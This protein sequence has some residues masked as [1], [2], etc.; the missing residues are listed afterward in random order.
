MELGILVVVA[1]AVAIAACYWPR[2]PAGASDRE[3]APSPADV[4][5]AA[6]ALAL[7]DV[8]KLRD[9]NVT[10]C[11][12]TGD[13]LLD[14]ISEV[15]RRAMPAGA[16]FDRLSGGRFVLW[17]PYTTLRD[18]AG[19][20]ERIR[21]LASTALADSE[22]GIVS[23]SLSAGLVAAYP[24]ESRERAVLRADA[25][26]ARA[27]GFGGDRTEITRALPVPAL[28]PAQAEIENA[29]VERALE[30][31]VQP[32]VDLRDR[33]AVGVE[34]LLRW[35]RPGGQVVGPMNFVDTLRR[36]PQTET[37]LFPDIAIEAARPLITGDKSFYTTFNVDGP[38]LEGKD[39][40]ATRWLSVL[41]E[42]LPPEQ[43]V[44]EIVETAVIVQPESALGFLER[45]RARGIRIALDDFGT[46]LSSLNRL[47]Q[48]PVDI[49][50]IDRVFINGL[51]ETGR[52]EAI[53]EGLVTL[54][55]RLGLDL[56]AEGI[57]TEAQARILTELGV[58]Y[59]Q[60]YHLGRPAPATEWARRLCNRVSA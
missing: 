44:L 32:I 15:I 48:F 26:L 10:R 56:I 33:R 28:I 23:R 12:D 25:A 43:L 29:I 27:K 39:G 8:D 11:Y 41:L 57:E 1:T 19:I 49:L 31:H 35:N 17:L 50:K 5:G 18:A 2:P 22:R 36:L 42:R 14:A 59:G 53:V 30:Y 40:P 13:R 58:Q 37:E 20:V 52:E 60:G 45:L 21:A 34:A 55:D 7:F 4:A 6:G 9:V 51:G 47:R 38:M 16:T 54:R 24:E 46:G 3:D